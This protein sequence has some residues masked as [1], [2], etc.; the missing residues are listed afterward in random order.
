MSKLAEEAFKITMT[1]YNKKY[2]CQMDVTSKELW[3]L[4]I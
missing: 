2:V 3:N 1:L 4:R